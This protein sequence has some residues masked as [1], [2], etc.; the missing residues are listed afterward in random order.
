[1]NGRKERRKEGNEGRKA[2]AEQARTHAHAC[3]TT[4]TTVTTTT[5]T[6]TTVTTTTVTT[7]TVTTTTVTTTTVATT[8][9]TPPVPPPSRR[10][11]RTDLPP[12]AHRQGNPQDPCFRRR[13][14]TLALCEHLHIREP[15][16][17]RDPASQSV[18]QSVSQPVS[19][20]AIQSASQPVR[21]RRYF[22]AISL[23]YDLFCIG[24]CALKKKK[25][26]V[27]K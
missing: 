15:P 12:P 8:N 21:H 2:G 4:T 20:S 9:A 16:P 23:H 11:A 5:V 19:Q 24:I 18:S 3:I 26:S 1:M 27:T 7:T 25:E 17:P 6:T 14:R 10:Y 22:Q 13:G